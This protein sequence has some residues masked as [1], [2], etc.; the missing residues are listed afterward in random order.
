MIDG[1]TV[2]QGRRARRLVVVEML[3]LGGGI[4]IGLILA[5]HLTGG[6]A[7]DNVDAAKRPPL[8]TLWAKVAADGSIAE[9]ESKGV[10]ASAKP[11]KGAYAVIFNRN[12]QHCAKVATTEDSV[13][14]IA[15]DEASARAREVEVTIFT[16]DQTDRLDLGFS[17][18]V[19]C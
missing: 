14:L 12:V 9:G 13:G 11:G 7:I 5:L 2:H 3:F 15:A 17:L 1:A 18:A 6:S 8:T 16:G 19:H 4:G 10:V